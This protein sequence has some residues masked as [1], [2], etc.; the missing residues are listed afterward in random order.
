[1]KGKNQAEAGEEDNNDERDDAGQHIRS[2]AADE[3]PGKLL[4]RQPQ[5]QQQSSPRGREEEPDHDG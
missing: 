1:M 5:T 2:I 4:I 3:W